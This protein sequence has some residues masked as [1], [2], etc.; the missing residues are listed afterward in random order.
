MQCWGHNQRHQAA[1]A[2][3]AV[4]AGLPAAVACGRDQSPGGHTVRSL[5][6]ATSTGA[7]CHLATS[8]DHRRNS[9]GL[10]QQHDA[11][12]KHPHHTTYP[13]PCMLPHKRDEA[14]G[15]RRTGRQYCMCHLC[16]VPN[17]FG[18]RQDQPEE[19]S[20]L[21]QKCGKVKRMRRVHDD[22]RCCPNHDAGSGRRP[23]RWTDGNREGGPR[24]AAQ[25]DGL[26]MGQI[27]S[28]VA[29]GTG[30]GRSVGSISSH[31]HRDHGLRGLPAAQDASPLFVSK[32]QLHA[33]TSQKNADLVFE[34]GVKN[35]R[36]AESRHVPNAYTSVS[37]ST[38]GLKEMRKGSDIEAADGVRPLPP[39]VS[40]TVSPATKN[41]HM[42]MV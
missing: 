41:S 8:E 39:L 17:T 40:P 9:A 27:F 2:R 22:H 29:H 15:G 31:R 18:A 33:L 1:V 30:P 38:S 12:D 13:T 23:R 25:P 32:D 16:N 36:I 6:G 5:R 7:S 11:Y 26:S 37:P 24:H 3:H 19:P 21:L 34:P 28:H 42:T 10:S 35:P 14:G 20:P 4:A